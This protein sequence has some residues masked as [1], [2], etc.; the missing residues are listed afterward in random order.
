MS[1]KL[2][3]E[4]FRYELP[5]TEQRVLLAYADHAD[6][7]NRCFP[8]IPYIA[9]KLGYK[10]KRMVERLVK[11]L[12]ERGVLIPEK[13]ARQ[14]YAPTWR[15]DLSALDRKPDFVRPG[16]QTGADRAGLQ[17]GA[18]VSE[19]VHEPVLEP[20]Q[21]VTADDPEPVNRAP[22]PVCSAPGPVNRA[23]RTGPQTGLTVEPSIKPTEGKRQGNRR[24]RVR[25]TPARES[26]SS[27]QGTERSDLPV[28]VP[29]AE[30]DNSKLDLLRTAS[31]T[32]V[33]PAKVNGAQQYMA[34]NTESKLDEL[35]RLQQQK[36]AA[37]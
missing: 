13:P 2:M 32:S 15:I 21:V 28:P 30:K 22:E 26:R 12:R 16:A 11:S 17:T 6:E 19:P 3:G 31:A 23:A 25:R 35:R 9:W 4:V 14:H 8:S 1:A 37:A 7:A 18:E 29:V 34:D 20:E 33:I 5:H 10:D 27:S 24:T 36:E